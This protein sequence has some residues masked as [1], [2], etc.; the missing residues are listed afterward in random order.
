M[1]LAFI[2]VVRALMAS[3]DME[4]IREAISQHRRRLA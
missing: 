4:A 1:R 3:M 2:R